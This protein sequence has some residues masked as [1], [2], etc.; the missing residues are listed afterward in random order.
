[1]F[2][3]KGLAIGVPGHGGRE[4][5]RLSRDRKNFS[6]VARVPGLLHAL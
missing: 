2:Q 1:M 3:F 6:Q 5:N 4:R